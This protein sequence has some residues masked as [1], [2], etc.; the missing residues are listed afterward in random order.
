MHGKLAR[1]TMLAEVLTELVAHVLA[2]AVGLQSPD[3]LS[4]LDL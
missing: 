3:V 1:C 2:S 4:E